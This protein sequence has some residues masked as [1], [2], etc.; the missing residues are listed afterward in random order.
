[1]NKA[2]CPKCSSN[3]FE[4][5]ITD[6]KENEKIHF[7]ICSTC[8][9]TIGLVDRVIPVSNLIKLEN[10]PDSIVFNQQAILNNLPKT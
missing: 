5:A 9:T 6:V 3:Q 8:N 10:K 1:M 7:V 4:M 2:K